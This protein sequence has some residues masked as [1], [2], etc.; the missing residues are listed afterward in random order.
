[1]KKYLFIL[2]I[3]AIVASCSDI[4]TFKQVNTP[5][6]AIGF[7]T[8]TG[9]LTRAENSTASVKHSLGNYHNSFK[10]WGSKTVNSTTSVVFNA[11]TVSTAPAPTTPEELYDAAGA[12]T[13]NAT[14][15]GAL[16][17]TD[18]LT[19]DQAT[20]YNA[21]TQPE[22]NK[23]AGNTLSAEEA[24][25]YNA[26]LA[27]AVKAGDIK[28]EAVYDWTYTPLVFWD[29]SATSY[30]FNAAAPANLSWAFADDKISL[31][32]FSVDG[33]TIAAS[34]TIDPKAV[35]GPKDIMI[36]EDIDAYTNFTSA[37]VNLSFIHLLSRLNIGVAKSASLS[38]HVVKLNSITVYN[39]NSNGKFEENAANATSTTP[40]GKARWSAPGAGQNTFTSGKGY[41]TETVL[42]TDFNYVYQTLAI[43]QQVD[44]EEGILLN[45]SNVSTTSKPYLNI[46][47]SIYNGETKL[48]DYNYTYNLAD[49]FNG[50]GQTTSV[51][52]GEGWMNTLKITINPVA[53]DFD[54]DIYEWAPVTPVEVDVPDVNTPA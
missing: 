8:Y 33:T 25:A 19:A 42:T 46:S 21:A 9:K 50:D 26:T 18:A 23:E 37:P 1:M 49:M 43:P 5:D 7:S 3:A 38:G 14:L 52:F 4:D 12:I 44:Y 29:K 27:G 13:K 36:S 47:Y 31:D 53:I 16:N 51:T 54:A 15:T 48:D 22:T 20:A 41:S 2:T 24:A 6:E 30:S 34:A 28:T 11:Q 39:L 35:F 10:V 45:G 17:S 40:G 32:N